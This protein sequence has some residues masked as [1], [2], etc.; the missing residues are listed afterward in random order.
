MREVRFGFCFCSPDWEVMLVS[1]LGRWMIGSFAIAF[2]CLLVVP[3]ANAD[4]RHGYGGY[5]SVRGEEKQAGPP[6]QGRQMS[7][8]DDA[9]QPPPPHYQRGHRGEGRGHQRAQRMSP[10]ERRQLRRDV[11][12][13]GREIYR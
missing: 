7:K 6:R 3:V 8:S 4:P 1:G 5:Y 2:A 9:R 11:R 10:E 13:A 12:D